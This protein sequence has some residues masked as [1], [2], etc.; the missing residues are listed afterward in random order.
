MPAA[1]D[2]PANAP[3]HCPG[4]ESEQAGKADSC[5]GCP[6]QAVCAS[7]PKGPDPAIPIITSRL[8]NV[9]HKILVLS[10]K[11]GV[12]KST[13]TTNLAF[14][15]SFDENVQVGIMDVDICGPSLP[16][17]TGLEEEQ[18]RQSSTGWAPVYVNDN[19]AVMS[20]GFMLQNQDDAV[21]WRGAKKNGMI[22][23][24]L[25][26]V[27]W[28]DL[29]YLLVDTP[30]GTSDEHLS[31]VQY[32]KETQITGAVVI[33]TPQEVSLQDVRKELNFCK[34]V[35][36][37][38]I[39]VVENMSGFVCPKCTK[40]SVIFAPT[41]GGAKKMCDDVGVPFLGAI[42]LDPRI[43]KSCDL[44]ESF[45]DQYQDSPAYGAY[46]GV[47]DSEYCVIVCLLGR[48]FD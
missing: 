37:P 25:K 36:I 28:G 3:E 6:N 30:P 15:L 21:I 7:G 39:G 24:F 45:L 11:G 13:F 1:E 9:K 33:T 29:D 2:V 26:D 34:K 12:G 4:T 19:L 38:I 42:P 8:S 43:G 47:I 32:L 10:G 35:G 18:I 22:K 23:Q 31:V 46:M 16:K 5:A 40:E 17:M 27:D 14:A 20:V 44:G 48:N 41:T